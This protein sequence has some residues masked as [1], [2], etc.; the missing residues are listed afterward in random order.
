MT[1]YLI[2]ASARTSVIS[3]SAILRAVDIPAA[4]SC[5]ALIKRIEDREAERDAELD[6]AKASAAAAAEASAEER[7]RARHAEAFARLEAR[8]A[9]LDREARERAETLALA[10]LQRIAPS[11]DADRLVAAL[12]ANAVAEISDTV[13]LEVHV[14]PSV[15]ETVQKR[16]AGRENLT[17][18]ADASISERACLVV[19]PHGRVDA[20]LEMQLSALEGAF[21]ARRAEGALNAA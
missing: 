5:T 6:E 2:A 20:S 1:M 16:L 17:I 14:H 18:H 10:I 7:V 15:A 21:T 9:T 12:A 3:D 13:T 11:L 8:A 19:G 4:E